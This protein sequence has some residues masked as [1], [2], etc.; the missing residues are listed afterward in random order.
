M[1]YA[2]FFV[3]TYAFRG[4]TNLH[5][6]TLSLN[7]HTWLGTK[8]VLK[9]ELGTQNKLPPDMALG[10]DFFERRGEKRIDIGTLLAFLI[11][12]FSDGVLCFCR[13]KSVVFLALVHLQVHMCAYGRIENFFIIL[14]DATIS[15]I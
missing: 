1:G 3:A 8:R 13:N 6:H 7:L 2:K 11:F 15:D 14:P 12:F 4:G 5:V 10:C 9:T